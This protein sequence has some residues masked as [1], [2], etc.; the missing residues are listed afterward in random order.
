MRGTLLAVNR[1]CFYTDDK[2]PIANPPAP[3]GVFCP[4]TRC[5]PVR[6]SPTPSEAWNPHANIIARLVAGDDCFGMNEIEW[7]LIA[8]VDAA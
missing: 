8:F 1:D 7:C 3:S 4:R 2:G 5:P 6:N